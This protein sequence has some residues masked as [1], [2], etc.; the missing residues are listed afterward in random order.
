MIAVSVRL[1]AT[2]RQYHPQAAAGAISVQLDEGATVGD[3]VQRLGIPRQAV[4]VTFVN[5]LVVDD[6]A[7]L[8]EGD[9]VGIFPPIAGGG[10]VLFFQIRTPCEAKEH[11]FSTW[12]PPPPRVET[13]SLE[14]AWGRV[15]AADVVVP[16]D[17]PEFFRSTV[18]GYAVRAADTFGAGEGLPAYLSVVGEVGMGEAPRVRVGPGEAAWIPT[19]GMLPE[20]ADAVV[21]VEHTEK[22]DRRTV[23]VKRAVGPG[24]NLIR[25]GEDFP[26]GAVALRR[27]RRLAPQDLGLLAGIGATE[28]PVAVPPAVAL[29]ST[30]DEIVPPQVEPGPGQIRD[31]NTYTLSALVRQEGG[32]PRFFGLIPDVYDAL[33]AA[34]RRAAESSDLI[35]IS[36]GSSVGPRDLVARAIDAIGSPGV[37]VH[38]VSMKPGKPTIL[39]A[40]G[41]KAVVGLP[42]HP[43][44]VMIVFYVFAREMIWRL[45]GL[46]ASPPVPLRARLARRVASAPGREDYLRVFLERRNG[47][48][49]AVPLLGK[50][51]LIATMVKADGLVRVPLEREGVE[52]GEPVE[53]WTW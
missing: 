26:A 23:E 8:Q 7:R 21:M 11:F 42:G 34:L 33:L 19:G 14:A 35:L 50:S 6:T 24:E 13:V 28:V 37:L 48:L 12:L 47:E 46:E 4:R 51:G 31:I 32:T 16:R 22:L 53:V 36:G 41:G 38:G 30:G 44:T 20:G 40:A 17:L 1:F 29:I 49:W 5:G 25:P 45:L 39:G 27:G 52:V 9:D 10:E 3:L 15:L 2:L 43:T 18:D